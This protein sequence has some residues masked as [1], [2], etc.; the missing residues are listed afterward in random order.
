MT[1]VEKEYLRNGEWQDEL[2]YVVFR[3]EWKPLWE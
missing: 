3:D 1:T 2:Q